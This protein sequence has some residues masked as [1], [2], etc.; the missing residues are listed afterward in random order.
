MLNI[1]IIEDEDTAA[2]ELT[3]FIKQYGR[4][5]NQLFHITRF[6]YATSLLKNYKPIYDIIFMDILL[7]NM[8][9]MEASVRLREL[10]QNVVLVFVTNM[11]NFAVKGYEVDALDF[12][13][14]PVGYDS[15]A[16]KMSK[17]VTAAARRKSYDIAI[18]LDGAMKIISAY[19]VYYIEADKHYLIYYTEE[20]NFRARGT[21]STLENNLIPEK[22]FRCNSCYLV[23][24]KFITEVEGNTVV[25][26]PGKLKISRARKKDFMNALTNYFGRNK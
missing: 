16:M 21:L 7:P 11:A 25:V 18:P 12:I 22:F 19:R 9:G 8:N 20:G 5:T 14:K 13:I 26:G 10:D 1:A 3:R 4:E 23:N 2:E 17:A 24:M 15:F 6:P